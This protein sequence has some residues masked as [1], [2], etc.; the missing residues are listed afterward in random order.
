MKLKKG[1]FMF[2][3]L[4]T[5]FTDH[6][7]IK[8]VPSSDEQLGY[9]YMKF[10][11]EAINNRGGNKPFQFDANGVPQIHSYIDVDKPGYYYYPI[12]IGQY[13]LAVFHSFLSTQDN[14]KKEHFL[15]IADW[16]LDTSVLDKK[17][18]AYWLTEVDKPEFNMTD[19]WKSSFSQS[20][21]LSILLRAWQITSDIKYMEIAKRALIPFL[22]D[23]KEGGVRVGK[24]GMFFYEEYVASAPTRILD[25]MMFSLFG[26]H[27][28]IRCAASIDEDTKLNAQFAFNQGVNGLCSWLPRFDMG[29]WVYYNRCEIPGYPQNDPCTIG[30]LRL[31]VSQLDILYTLTKHETLKKYRDQFRSYVKPVN[32]V[33]MYYQKYKA[34]K[35]LNRL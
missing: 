24:E 8:T 6:T 16:F 33:R 29:Y 10:S 4:I 9:Y 20:R 22:F 26:L 13:G 23:V 11:E 32:I 34:L 15:R 14:S 35:S 3:R 7:N 18:G 21:A 1:I 30:Y 5:D 17:L 28:M 27:D 25:G 31:V 2:K 12:T 19:P